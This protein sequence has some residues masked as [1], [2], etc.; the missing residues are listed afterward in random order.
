MQDRKAL[1]AGTSH[2]LGQN[3]AKA[4]EIKFT[5]DEGRAGVHAWTTSWGVS[6]RLI[7]GLIMTHADD[8][9][10]VLPPRLAPTHVVIIADHRTSPRT[11]SSV[12]DVLPRARARAARDALS[13]ARRVR[14]EV[15]ERDI[16]GGEKGGSGS[17]R[18]CRCASR[19]A[20]ATSKRLRS[21][22]ARRDKPEG[23]AEH[24]AR[25]VRRRVGAGML[26]EIQ[27]GLF[28]R[29][30]ATTRANTRARST[31][32]DEFYAF[33][34]PK[35]ARR[36]KTANADADPR[37]LR[38]DALRR[39]SRARDQD[40]GR[41]QGHRALHPARAGEPGTCPFTGQPSAKRV[42]WAKAY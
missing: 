13:P 14:V 31:R 17:R 19:S 23:Q 34:T 16:R 10:L 7:G 9:G 41:P 18:A 42:V 15:D 39:R 24:A 35:A 1:Q 26:Q 37:R 8:D 29:A 38:D 27:D 36:P 2:F 32:K 40:Q 22:V 21:F 11:R 12:L 30:K 28:A 25:R 4:S 5:D 6:T 20:R 33:F 3:F